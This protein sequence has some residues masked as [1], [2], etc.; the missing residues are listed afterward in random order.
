MFEMLVPRTFH[1]KSPTQHLLNLQKWI[2]HFQFESEKVW[3]NRGE[4]GLF[5]VSVA[6]DPPANNWNIRIHF[7]TLSSLRTLL[8]APIP[9]LTTNPEENLGN[10]LQ[11]GRRADLYLIRTLYSYKDKQKID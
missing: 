11:V 4:V 8:P 5:I 9:G 7:Q 6:L 10:H 2:V 1:L 3:K